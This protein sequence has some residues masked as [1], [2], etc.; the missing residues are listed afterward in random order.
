MDLNNGFMFLNNHFI[1]KKNMKNI[2]HWPSLLWIFLLT[3]TAFETKMN[4]SQ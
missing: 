2:C 1:K 3:I 4:V